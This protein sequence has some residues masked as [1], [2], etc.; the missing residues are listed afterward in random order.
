MI[1][2][3]KI[4]K[5][6]KNTGEAA[7]GTKDTDKKIQSSKEVNPDVVKNDEQLNTSNLFDD[8]EDDS[9]DPLNDSWWQ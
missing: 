2:K 8:V 3:V 9:D 7:S 6:K 1:R 4:I 5:R